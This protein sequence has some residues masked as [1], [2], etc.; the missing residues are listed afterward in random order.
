MDCIKVNCN[1]CGEKY[2]EL[3]LK[4]QGKISEIQQKTGLVPISIH[5]FSSKGPKWYCRECL[6]HIS[7]CILKY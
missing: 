7:D 6:D 5:N 3:P 1:H 2:Q 4:Y